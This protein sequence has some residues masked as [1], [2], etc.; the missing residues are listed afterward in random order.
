[1]AP[2]MN[3][4]IKKLKVNEIPDIYVGVT[5]F[6]KDQQVGIT[7]LHLRNKSKNNIEFT[8]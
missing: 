5:V 7:N 8:N 4:F 6:Y 3:E 2:H 1:M